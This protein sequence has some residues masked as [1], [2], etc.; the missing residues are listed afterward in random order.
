MRFVTKLLKDNA[1]MIQS[2]ICKDK[3]GGRIEEELRIFKEF[4]KFLQFVLGIVN[5]FELQD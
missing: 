3:L 4:L 2:I 5:I 1:K